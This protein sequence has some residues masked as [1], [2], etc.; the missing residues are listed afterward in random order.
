MKKNKGMASISQNKRRL[1]R[2][3]QKAFLFFIVALM[4]SAYSISIITAA[5]DKT[6]LK[7]NWVLGEGLLLRVKLN[8]RSADFAEYKYKVGSRE[9]IGEYYREIENL[10]R[11]FDSLR[12]NIW[13][14]IFDSTDYSNSA[15]LLRREDF[16]YWGI[17]Y[18]NQMV[19]GF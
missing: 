15:L 13:T 16:D 12:P 8:G 18:N 10:Y 6:D 3:R 4:I 11:E 2:R 9:Y 7:K 1:K 14:I 17:P 5:N 19:V